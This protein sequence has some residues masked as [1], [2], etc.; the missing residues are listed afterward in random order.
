M[1]NNYES[2]SL[3]QLKETY[4]QNH[5][6]LMDCLSGAED[7][8]DDRCLKIHYLKSKEQLIDIIKAQNGIIESLEKL[9]EPIKH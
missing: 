9:G 5:E 7:F 4:K 2:M 8:K 6:R 1:E 3:E